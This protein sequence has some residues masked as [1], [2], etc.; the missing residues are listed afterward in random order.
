MP[1]RLQHLTPPAECQSIGDVRDA[2]DSIDH[3]IVEAIGRRFEYVQEVTRF[4]RT[5]DEVHAAER[6]R[7]VLATRRGW[8]EEC[9]LN[10][11]VVEEMYR[12]L[13]GHFINH[14]LTVLDLRESREASGKA[15]QA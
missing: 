13:I 4:K 1:E 14:E 5:R 9:G 8:A 3:L 10:P 7:A 15:D 12:N 2:I 11:D 6:Y